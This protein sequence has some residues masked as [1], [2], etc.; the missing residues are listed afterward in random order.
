M[1]AQMGEFF[2]EIKV[3]ARQTYG[4]MTL[5]CVLSEHD[6]SVRFLTRDN[7]PANDA[8]TISELTEGGSSL[9]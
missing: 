4:N 5:Y 1:M 9:N 7:A 6:A 3:G 8:L 2:A